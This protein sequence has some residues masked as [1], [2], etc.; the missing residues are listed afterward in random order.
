MDLC[1]STT[2]MCWTSCLWIGDGAFYWDHHGLGIYS[3]AIVGLA[4]AW[5]SDH[6][7]FP[8]F[9]SYHLWQLH[10]SSGRTC[11]LPL[12]YIYIYIFIINSIR[13]VDVM[14]VFLDKVGCLEDSFTSDCG[15]K[16]G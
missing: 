15:H 1:S 9:G 3:T 4:Y 11:T 14:M 5:D 8:L 2:R 16:F 6:L 12:N 7:G 10:L 13:I